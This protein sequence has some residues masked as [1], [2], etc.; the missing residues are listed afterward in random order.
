MHIKIRTK[1]STATTTLRLLE[2]FAAL[3]MQQQYVA[4]KFCYK[5]RK[6]SIN[7]IEMRQMEL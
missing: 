6:S 1:N 5:D 7:A 3:K 2:D 4:H